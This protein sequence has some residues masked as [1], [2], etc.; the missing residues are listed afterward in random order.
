MNDKVAV[1]DVVRL[2]SGGN[3]MTVVQIN[4]G[5]Y[6]NVDGGEKFIESVA[7]HWMDNGHIECSAYPLSCLVNISL[8]K[9]KREGNK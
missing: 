2:N 5:N 3:R 8:D 4:Y 7:V 1:G 9:T 6:I